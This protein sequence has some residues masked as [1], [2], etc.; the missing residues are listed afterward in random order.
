MCALARAPRR[1][2]TAS[3]DRQAGQAGFTLVEVLAVL[4]VLAIVGAVAV[5]RL[6]PR[7]DRDMLQATAYELASRCRAARLTAIRQAANR[8]VFIDIEN[9]LVTAGREVAPLKIADTISIYS[10]TSAASPTSAAEQGSQRIAAIRFLPN[11]SSTGGRIRLETGRQAY[12]VRVN[13]LS[14][15]V[16]VERVS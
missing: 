5:N 7:H 10:H 6:G 13:W 8:T 15:R 1:G 12:E 16:V 11:G 14:G 4:V 9:R 2:G 3:P